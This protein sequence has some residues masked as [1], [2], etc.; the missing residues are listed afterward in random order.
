[1][2]DRTN[3][4]AFTEYPDLAPTVETSPDSF[5]SSL[6][7]FIFKKV[8]PRPGMQA[9][10]AVIFLSGITILSFI[11]SRRSLSLNPL[12]MT[13]WRSYSWPRLVCLGV[14]LSSWAFLYAAGILVLGIGMSQ[15]TVSC[16]LGIFS[17]IVFYA[18]SKIFIYLFLIEK[19]H[20]IGNTSLPRLKSKLY[21]ACLVAMTPY[22]AVLVL[23]IAGRIAE[24][25]SNG[26]C[27]IGLA[28]FASLSLLIYDL[29]LNVYLTSLFVWP[30]LTS[31]CST[32]FRLL[33]SL[34]CLVLTF[35]SLLVSQSST[36]RSEP[37]LPGLS[38]LMALTTST[39]NILVLTLMNGRQLGFV[40]L[41]SCGADVTI[42]AC[43]LFYVTWSP[44]RSPDRDNIQS[45]QNNN[46]KASQ[47]TAIGAR[48]HQK[49]VNGTPRNAK[50]GLMP[51][52]DYTQFPEPREEISVEIDPEDG[53]GYAI[54]REPAP[55]TTRSAG[56]GAIL[57]R[58]AAFSQKPFSMEDREKRRAKGRVNFGTSEG[59][60]FF[61]GVKRALGFSN[62]N[63]DQDGEKD[64]GMNSIQ[65]H[66]NTEIAEA[67]FLSAR[68]QA[69]AAANSANAENELLEDTNRRN[70]LAP[71][72]NEGR[73]PF[74]GRTNSGGSDRLGGL[75]PSLNHTDSDEGYDFDDDSTKGKSNGS[76]VN[77][78]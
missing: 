40:C 39:I 6:L 44:S 69:A 50:V 24:I 8:F 68:G 52:S 45:G 5:A 31:K 17:C 22:V 73:S 30:I 36:L 46:Q 51:R 35:S 28:K 77:L 27:Y 42:N 53:G 64:V 63:G 21:I 16:S 43:V 66:V 58:E 76:K 48:S 25:T 49:T 10:S 54:P 70:N 4:T 14:F 15:S 55:A 7:I 26:A 38:A 2:T 32:S 12:S 56:G 20:I 13:S 18:L 23:M 71:I 37:S 47:V 62:G 19:V 3:Y 29:F 57:A 59:G 9:F 78:Q 67:E 1:M 11:T 74:V 41:G 33:R 34:R 65:V 75:V 61:S 60:G 72:Y